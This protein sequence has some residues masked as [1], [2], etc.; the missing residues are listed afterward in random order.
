MPFIPQATLQDEY[1]PHSENED[2]KYL[3]KLNE[4]F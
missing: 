3:E 2:A 4:L 1:Y